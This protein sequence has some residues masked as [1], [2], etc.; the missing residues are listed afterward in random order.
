MGIKL[1]IVD[2]GQAAIDYLD[3]STVDLIFMDGQMP[4]LDHFETTAHLRARGLSAAIIAL[5]VYAL[6][7]KE[8]QCL[9][10]GT[11][12]FLSKPFLQSELKAVLARW[13]DAGVIVQT[14]TSDIVIRSQIKR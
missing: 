3:E 1:A 4:H 13:L 7:E 9:S 14:G 2:N 8:Q 6:E 11:S 12:A 5:K 10:A